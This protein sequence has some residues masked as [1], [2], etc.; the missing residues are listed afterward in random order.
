MKKSLKTTLLVAT[1]ALTG[2][3]A[4]QG[5]NQNAHAAVNNNDGTVTVQ[6]GD[7]Y[8]SI[9]KQFNM[10]VANLETLN[11]RTVGGYDLIFP[12]ETIKVNGTQ[13]TSNTTS[14]NNTQVAAATTTNTSSN[15]TTTSNASSTTSYTATT[16]ASSSEEAAKAW[17][18][19]KESGG[20]YTA[21]NGQYVG[22]YQLSASYLNGDYS[23]ANQER[24]ANNY[25]TSRY[26]SW[27][28][29]EAFWQANGWY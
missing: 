20:S 19:N 7:S 18:A 4:L 22:K 3:L 5:A 17:I 26:G 10:T 8:M 23:A 1:T 6:S 29:A 24:V 28:A 25:V 16:S 21:T 12:G 14:N 11:G 13:T 9:A 15:Y 2:V 27:T